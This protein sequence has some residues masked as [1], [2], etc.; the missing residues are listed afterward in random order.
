[1]TP[2]LIIRRIDAGLARMRER[3]ME[4]RAIYLT[5]ADFLLLA[6][7]K[8]TRWRR[9]T[10]SKALV[11]PLSYDDVPL[12]SE[13]LIEQM[14]PVRLAKGRNGSTIYSTRGVTVAVPRKQ[15]EP[16]RAAA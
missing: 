2:P 5:P 1:V 3:G 12:I 8:T 6:R 16:L 13:K 10:G 4:P 15:P 9:E 14:V 11:W 7:A